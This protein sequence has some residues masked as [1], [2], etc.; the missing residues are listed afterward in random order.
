MSESLKGKTVIEPKP[1]KKC[2]KS[3]NGEHEFYGVMHM[4]YRD[5]AVWQYACKK[6]GE[7]VTSTYYREDDDPFM[8][9]D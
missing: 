4:D 8:W 2:S 7:Q 6:C 9:M 3:E 5:K 1:T